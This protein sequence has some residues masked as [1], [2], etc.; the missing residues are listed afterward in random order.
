M[1]PVDDVASWM[2]FLPIEKMAESFS[3]NPRDRLLVI[4]GITLELSPKVV[5]QV[6]VSS[7]SVVVLV[8]HVDI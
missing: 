6:K 7:M 5:W 8:F 3:R 1:R 2:Q 4:P